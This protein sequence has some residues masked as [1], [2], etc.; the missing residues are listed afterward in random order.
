MGLWGFPATTSALVTIYIF[1]PHHQP[2]TMGT[3]RR[4]RAGTRVSVGRF[5]GRC[6]YPRGGGLGRDARACPGPADRRHPG[7]PHPHTVAANPVNA[8]ARFVRD[9]AKT[10]SLGLASLFTSPH[11]KLAVGV[12][13]GI[14]AVIWLTITSVVVGL[15]RRVS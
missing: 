14:A 12:H 2:A 13:Y 7:D 6:R 8:F 1:R 9:G 11:Q 3:A 4:R 10:F 15:V 5:G